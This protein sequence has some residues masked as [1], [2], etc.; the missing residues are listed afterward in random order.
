MEHLQIDAKDGTYMEP[1]L[2]MSVNVEAGSSIIRGHLETLFERTTGSAIYDPQFYLCFM[3]GT[4]DYVPETGLVIQYPG[5]G[6]RATGYEGSHLQHTPVGTNDPWL[7]VPNR[8]MWWVNSK[9]KDELR[10]LLLGK[11]LD[12]A[13]ATFLRNQVLFMIEGI[14]KKGYE[15]QAIS[16]NTADIPEIPPVS[17]GGFMTSILQ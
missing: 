5:T 15:M 17:S 3:S 10:T 14:Y 1:R 12:D 9:S 6:K 11:A 13:E 4:C 8:A 16:F 2:R 7:S